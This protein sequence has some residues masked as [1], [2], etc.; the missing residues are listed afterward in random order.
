VLVAEAVRLVGDAKLI[1]RVVEPAC[2][3]DP[4]VPVIV[5]E[6]AYGTA[7]LVVLIVS[8]EVPLPM[9]CGGLNPPLLTPVGKPD[10]YL[11]PRVTG[12]LNPRSG[13]IVTLKVVDCPGNTC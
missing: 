2:P 5:K 7:A 6:P 10:G 3:S 4:E 11:T 13:V 1:S 9:I 12:L 8:M